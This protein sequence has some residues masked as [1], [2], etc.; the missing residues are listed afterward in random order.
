MHATISWKHL[1]ILFHLKL[2]SVQLTQECA[3]ITFT[4]WVFT[5]DEL[6]IQLPENMVYHKIYR[7]QYEMI[8]IGTF[9]AY[10]KAL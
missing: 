4:M 5:K 8:D 6:F 7:Y 1:T 10:R 2:L 3:E 9:W